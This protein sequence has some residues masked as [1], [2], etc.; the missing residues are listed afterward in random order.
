MANP[1]EITCPVCGAANQAHNTACSHCGLSLSTSVLA[2]A[3][4]AP[5]YQQTKRNGSASP[6]VP[7]EIPEQ[8][9]D[10]ESLAGYRQTP[11][12]AP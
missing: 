7:P 8:F 9:V 10:F 1:T 3:H 4:L 5:I 6:T 12:Y 11:G 2:T